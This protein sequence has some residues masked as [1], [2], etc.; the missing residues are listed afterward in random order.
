MESFESIS[1]ILK[2]FIPAFTDESFAVPIDTP[3][4]DLD[5]T[6]R[7]KTI[8]RREGILTLEMLLTKFR[9]YEDVKAIKGLGKATLVDI[10]G[11][12]QH[13]GYHFVWDKSI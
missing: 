5:F 1:E 8:M 13:S 11:V 9:H 3:V 7:A 12:V 4:E 2:P 6:V 10:V